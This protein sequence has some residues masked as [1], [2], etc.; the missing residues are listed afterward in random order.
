MSKANED[1]QAELER[2][3]G[4]F[5]AF[6]SAHEGIA[7]IRE[8]Y[9]K[10]EREVFWGPSEVWPEPMLADP[11][12]TH[13][14]RNRLMRAEAVQLAAMALRFIEDVCDGTTE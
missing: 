8:E 10:L 3:R 6:R 4:K 14:A 2:A 12:E 13:H 9:L 5:P 11:S 1:V 7:I